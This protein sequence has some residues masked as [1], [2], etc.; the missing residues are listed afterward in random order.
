M[1]GDACPLPDLIKL[2]QTHNSMLLI[3]EAHAT[4]VMGKT[5]AGIVEH[6][7]CQRE[8]IVQIGTLSKALGSVG[9]YVAGSAKLIDY[10]RNRAATWIYT[11]GLSPADTAA[12][13]E[14]IRVI[15][16][17]PQRR[18]KLWANVAFFKQHLKHLDFF[19]T[20][21]P[22]L[23]LKSGKTEDAL[24]LSEKLRQAGTFVPAI[25]PPTVPTSRLRFSLMATHDLDHIQKLVTSLK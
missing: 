9:G 2:A 25:R 17:E 24:R 12:A 13:L 22:I 7:G 6:F 8:G 1:N 21:S 18:Q 11:T 3:D 5:G 20:D 16:Q 4:G 15:H 23:C 10:L 14:A 19:P